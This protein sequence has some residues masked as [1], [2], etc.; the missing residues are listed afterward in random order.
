MTEL[1]SVRPEDLLAELVWVRTLARSLVRDADQAEDEGDDCC[2][3]RGCNCICCGTAVVGALI[4][5]TP[6]HVTIAPRS[7][8]VALPVSIRL[9]AQGIVVSGDS[10]HGSPE[11]RAITLRES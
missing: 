8:P 2:S 1:S 10:L 7:I 9:A 4:R 5:S 11:Y 3:S 6:I